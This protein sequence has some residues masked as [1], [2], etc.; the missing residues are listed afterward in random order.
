MIVYIG[1]LDYA[2]GVD[3]LVD[4]LP[5]LRNRCHAACLA[6]AGEGPMHGHLE[7]QAR[8]LGLSHA[9]RVLGDL[10]RDSVIRLLRAS[11]ALAM[12]SRQRIPWD[13]A[14]VDM[15][16]RAGKPVIT[17]QCGP[18]HLVRHE[19]NGILTFD[20]PNSMVWAME[21]MLREPD[22]ARRLGEN[23]KHAGT[24]SISWGEVAGRYLDL[25]A[26]LFPEL[27]ERPR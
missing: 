5:T 9:V 13:D 14:V 22:H 24:G 16:R 18:A 26:R 8:H 17:T 1:P 25:C 2:A 20:N 7:G 27:T 10:Q 19:V 15:A 6:F 21:R 3:L 4:A 12:P 23:G 11:E